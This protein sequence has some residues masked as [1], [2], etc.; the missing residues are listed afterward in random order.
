M[1]SIYSFFIQIFEWLLP[2][3]KWISSKQHKFVEGRKRVWKKINS[4]EANEVIWFHTASL[5]EYEQ[6]VPVMKRFKEQYPQ[7]KIVVTFFS[8][9]GY[10][11]K[12]NDALP[13]LVLYLPLDTKANA[14]RFI[15]ALPI[16]LAI[17][18]K[19]EIWPN[20]LESLAQANIPS[21]LIA[22][23][24]RPDQIYFKPQ[25]QFL[26]KALHQFKHILVQNNASLQLLKN[27]GFKQVSISGDTRYDRV[28]QQLKMDNQLDFMD[29]FKQDQICFVIGSS[30]PEDEAVFIDFVNTSKNVKF[31][32]APHE[33]KSQKTKSLVN[34]IHKNVVLH[35]ELKNSDLT[36]AEVIVID[37]VGLLS[38]I[39]AY[40]DLAY[41]GG[42]MGN[43]GLHNILEPA[44]F[45]IPIII[46]K[47]FQKF[48][49]A[50]ELRT[51]AGLFSVENA[52]EFSEI[53]GKL[54]DEDEFRAQT[55]V[56]AGQF[57][58]HRAGATQK[59]MEKAEPYLA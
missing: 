31:V 58:D 39:Y 42:G 19:Y 46:G 30:W 7:T 53:A 8:P 45:G 17:F 52:Q 32:I 4:F 28:I 57:V 54:V 20:Y 10:E 49:E 5:G 12:K 29:E 21:L 33:I 51:Y 48:P 18:V 14:S 16:K 36:E 43:S 50:K 1:K 40:A 24:F 35:S 11:V 59:I 37:C 56:I 27:E 34:Q 9:S 13:H 22:A 55:G 2:F 23:L 6:A 15:D 3:T 38:K 41:V 26:K 47:N 25:G 44:T